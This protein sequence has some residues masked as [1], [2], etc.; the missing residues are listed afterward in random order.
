MA[1][2][3]SDTMTAKEKRNAADRRRYAAQNATVRPTEP[4]ET[5]D[6]TVRRVIDMVHVS[7]IRKPKKPQEG[8]YVCDINWGAAITVGA[9]LN[10]KTGS[11]QM[12]RFNWQRAT[13]IRRNFACAVR[14]KV[15]EA[16]ETHYTQEL[17]RTYRF[18]DKVK[19]LCNRK[20][21]EEAA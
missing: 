2:A 15:M 3:A 8:L 20:Q 21:A 17:G 4:V 10:G 19:W 16:I 11:L 12:P 18:P 5:P 1:H 9:R 14:W 6:A 7:N 13:V